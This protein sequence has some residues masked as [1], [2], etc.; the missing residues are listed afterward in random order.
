M[1][2]HYPTLLEA[3]VN[4]PSSHLP[5]G[6]NEACKPV[7]TR[8]S[9]PDEEMEVEEEEGEGKEEDREEGS[10][11]GHGGRWPQIASVLLND[12][13]VA[14]LVKQVR[15]ARHGTIPSTSSSC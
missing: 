1:L 15:R 8:S 14:P 11:E 13:S 12:S 2:C 3:Q 5:G 6:F 7:K 4:N 9:S 10:G